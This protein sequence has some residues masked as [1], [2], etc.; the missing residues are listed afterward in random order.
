M[1]L[2]YHLPASSSI[3]NRLHEQI[4][5]PFPFEIVLGSTNRYEAVHRQNSLTGE[6]IV[7]LHKS[8]LNLGNNG[9][10]DIVVSHGRAEYTN[11][12]TIPIMFT[13]HNKF[14]GGGFVYEGYALPNDPV[15]FL[16]FPD[17]PNDPHAAK[18]LAHELTHKFRGDTEN[19]HCKGAVQEK[20]C[21]MNPPQLDLSYASDME[22]LALAFCDP[23]YE[24]LE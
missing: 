16:N 10:I 4:A 7:Q 3:D 12:K 6:A 2:H 15:V 5:Q 11:G 8:I 18:I 20:N 17:D 14:A 21:I 1:I 22:R 13:S 23:C 19:K 9:G 24:S